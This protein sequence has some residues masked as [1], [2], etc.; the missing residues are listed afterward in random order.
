MSE[1]YEVPVMSKAAIAPGVTEVIFDISK[2]NFRFTA[3]QYATITLPDATAQPTTSQFH[4][5]S[6]ASSPN[7]HERLKIAFRNSASFFKTS[8]LNLPLGGM[9]IL[10]GPSGN[11]TLPEETDRPI[12]CIA[13]G[14][15][16]TPFMSMLTAMN[17]MKQDYKVTLFYS[18]RD[19]VSTA[20]T[21]DLQQLAKANPAVKLVFTMTNDHQWKG[22]TKA[23]EGDFVKSYLGDLSKYIFYIAGPPVMVFAV[24]DDLKQAGVAEADI[25]TEGFTGIEVEQILT[26]S[27]YNAIISSLDQT[28]LVSM[29]DAKGHI[30]Y[31]NQKFVET[32]KY[33]AGELM[34]QN[35]R[36]LKSGAQPQELFTK[37]W[38]DIS[39]G[40]VWHGEIKN[41]AKDNTFY[42]VDK[43]IAPVMGAGEH[44]ERYISVDFLITDRKEREQAL[45]RA[46]A[47]DEAILSSMSDGIIAADHNG[48]IILVNPA[49]E[50]LLGWNA[51][52]VLHTSI[53]DT[54]STKDEHGEDIP[55]SDSPFRQVFT[56]GKAV[57]RNQ[58]FVSKNG[59]S[60]PVAISVTP[61]LLGTEVL[62]VV[63]LFHNTI[64]DNMTSAA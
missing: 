42:W 29:T 22:E 60:I 50:K 16:V 27:D 44:P 38:D 47:L 64:P 2:T 39:H 55:L 28:A 14:I 58:Y 56:T 8:L 36:L 32:S 30:I 4:D 33:P 31:A 25:H 17:E 6:I 3:G 12:V 61:I 43:S 57:S 19:S 5:F 48:K 1:R 51:K 41:K 7:D 13:G 21:S 18:N 35:H 46:N 23:I 40:K 59:G 62:G 26:G 9:V 52:E 37:L 53:E 15:G 10:E 34:G 11:F 63:A 54:L 45:Q 24:R 20:Y 49:L